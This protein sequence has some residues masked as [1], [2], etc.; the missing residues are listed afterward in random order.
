LTARYQIHEER[1]MN[2]N[3]IVVC[4]L[5]DECF[6]VDIRRVYEIIRLQPITP[7]PAAP[8]YMEGVTNL[9][10]RI[11][12][13]VDL[14]GLFGLSKS[15]ASKASRIVVVGIGDA[16]VGLVVDGV[17]QVLMVPDDILEETPATVSGGHAPRYLRAIAKLPES[18]VMLLDLDALFEAGDL[19]AVEHA[20]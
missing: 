16:R 8:A 1:A 14:A 13:V 17:S 2:E 11:V 5:K 9:R 18:L 4:E 15:K 7:V 12:P 3:Q 10:G 6:G 20:A 19:Q